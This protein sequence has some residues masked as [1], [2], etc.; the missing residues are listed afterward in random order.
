MVCNKVSQ[1][2]AC[3]CGWLCKLKRGDI[4]IMSFWRRRAQ[5]VTNIGAGTVPDI[6]LPHHSTLLYTCSV[7]F[8]YNRVSLS[9]FYPFH[10][11][12]PLYF[13]ELK[14]KEFSFFFKF[15]SS[16]EIT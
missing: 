10:R 16:K 8:L 11:D 7:F 9:Y 13:I 14:I 15:L 6:I 1:F 12:V 5:T 3:L 2:G 4:Q